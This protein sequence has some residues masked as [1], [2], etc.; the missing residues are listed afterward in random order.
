MFTTADSRL[1][2]FTTVYSY[3]FYYDYPSL[4]VFIYGYSCLPMLTLVYI[5]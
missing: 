2:M 3:L 1:R 4:L 5:N